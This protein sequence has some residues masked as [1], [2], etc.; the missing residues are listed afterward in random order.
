MDIT[1][2]DEFK[3]N[4]YNSEKEVLEKFDKSKERLGEQEELSPLLNYVNDILSKYTSLDGGG[5]DRVYEHIKEIIEKEYSRTGSLTWKE[6]KV[7]HISVFTC[8]EAL[9][10]HVEFGELIGP[11]EINDEFSRIM[12]I[13][14]EDYLR[15]FSK[16][17]G[18]RNVGRRCRQDE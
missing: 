3:K 5:F 13:E 6:M 7:W 16:E 4:L 17:I 2:Q 10:K 14:F 18:T 1:Q 8:I 9:R 12:S 11:E 15:N